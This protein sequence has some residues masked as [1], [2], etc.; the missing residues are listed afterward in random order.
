MENNFEN[1]TNGF[2]S[3]F[4]KFKS[5]IIIAL[6]II[7]ISLVY[8]LFPKK[9][10]IIYEY[11]ITTSPNN[12][13][14]LLSN[15]E[16]KNQIELNDVI[17]VNIG[18]N[19]FKIPVVD[20]TLFLSLD[21]D[22]ALL[23]NNNILIGSK[24][25]N[26]SD[27]IDKNVNEAKVEIIK[28]NGYSF[29]DYL[30]KN[31]LNKYNY[32]DFS[33]DYEFINFLHLNNINLY[34]ANFNLNNDTKLDIFENIIDEMNIKDL[35]IYNME[36]NDFIYFI[37]TNDPSKHITLQNIFDENRILTIEPI[38]YNKIDNFYKRFNQII[39]MIY[40]NDGPYVFVNTIKNDEIVIYNIMFDALQ[41][42]NY[43]EMLMNYISFYKTYYKYEEDEKILN[44][45]FDK[46]L[47]KLFNLDNNIKLS[48]LQYKAILT[49]YIEDVDDMTL[50]YIINK[51]TLA[52]E[53]KNN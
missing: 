24:Y 8:I 47:K 17:N 46:L 3:F 28:K 32:R 25:T 31:E 7:T 23:Q 18:K 45:N 13:E 1:Q 40:N 38:D 11:N 6:V 21:D 37:R 10:K 53:N 41:N 44:N 12:M 48:E 29:G 2:S 35:I 20:N 39:K 42:K 5:I 14:I 22:Y 16:I 51:L 36:Y 30:E 49:D 19:N 52:S 34:S 15:P 33:N 9:E 27:K 50:N 4:T 26:F 43:N